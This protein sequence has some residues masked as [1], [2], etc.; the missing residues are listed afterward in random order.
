ISFR[1]TARDTAGVSLSPKCAG[2]AVSRTVRGPRP[3]TLRAAAASAARPTSS[4]PPQSPDTSPSERNLTSRPSGARPRPLI[5][6]PHTTAIPH[7][8]SVPAQERE[9]VVVHHEALAPALLLH[10]GAKRGALLG[11]VGA[12]EQEVG[13][14]RERA[15]APVETRAGDGALQQV[16][17]HFHTGCKPEVAGWHSS[18]TDP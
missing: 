7:P 1:K 16:L 10:S 11:L 9:R 4:P 17:E 13:R 18:P 6:A 8:R 2:T 12:C 3:S 14:R 5:P 15:R